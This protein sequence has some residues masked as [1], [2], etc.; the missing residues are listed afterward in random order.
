VFESRT[1]GPV[2]DRERG[3]LTRLRKL[4]YEELH[5]LYFS[6]N[7]IR[8]SKIMEVEMGEKSI[9]ISGEKICRK[10]TTVKT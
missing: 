8:M 7:T 4:H 3:E 1:R 2:L 10:A 6:P 5:N 9:R